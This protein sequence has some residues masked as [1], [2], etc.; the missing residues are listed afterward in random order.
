[1]DK[2]MCVIGIGELKID[3]IYKKTSEGLYLLKKDGGGTTWNVLCNLGANNIPTL[4]L[5]VCGDDEEGDIS[6]NSL[7]KFNVDV[8]HIERVKDKT[9]KIYVIIPEG[10]HDDSSVKGF[11]TSP[12]TGVKEIIQYKERWSE[13]INIPENITGIALI[14]NLREQC[15]TAAKKVKN[16]C[17]CK[18]VLDLG[19]VSYIRDI[20]NDDIIQHFKN[21]DILQVNQSVADFLTQK[22]NLDKKQILSTL[23]LEVMV[24]TKGSSGAEFVWN[25][26]RNVKHREYF[27][28]EPAQIVDSFGAGDAVLSVFIKNYLE[29]FN[30]VDSLNKR[31]Y[32]KVFFEG[33]KL[34]SKV[35]GCIGARGHLENKEANIIE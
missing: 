21:I 16:S 2:K 10:S 19:H 5:G 30:D 1:M 3:E 18:V 31:F 24:I 27:I 8:S 17:N 6:I 11:Y 25:G 15:L 20:N 28:N 29:I 32:D 7:K 13:Q 12:I 9:Q 4:A 35:M 33:T 34:T 14:D 23:D 26:K 22:M